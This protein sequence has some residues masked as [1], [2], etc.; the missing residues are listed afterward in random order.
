M[1]GGYKEDLNFSNN[2][3]PHEKIYNVAYRSFHL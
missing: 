1:K 2:I 3:I